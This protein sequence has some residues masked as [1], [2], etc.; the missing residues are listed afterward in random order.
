MKEFLN[1]VIF[2]SEENYIIFLFIIFSPGIY[3]EEVCSTKYFLM[4]IFIYFSLR[5]STCL[6][7]DNNSTDQSFS[8]LCFRR[9][10]RTVMQIIHKL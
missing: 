6:S 8:T 5:C 10:K 2:L 3:E 4:L 9:A 7:H 1:K